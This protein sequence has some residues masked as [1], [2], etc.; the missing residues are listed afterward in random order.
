M[1]AMA[2]GDQDMADALAPRRLRDRRKMRLVGRTWVDDG[3]AAAADDIGVGAEEGVGRGIV[4]DDAAHLR[5][6]LFGHAV[7]DIDASIEGKL[8]RHGPLI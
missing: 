2:M 5:S 3:H 7:V 4:G 6:D 8:C 1:V